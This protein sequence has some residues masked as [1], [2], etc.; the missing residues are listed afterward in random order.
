MNFLP[1]WGINK[2][3]KEI[4]MH[5][6][7]FFNREKSAVTLL[8]GVSSVSEMIA[9]A[10][11]AQDQGAD[12]VAFEI[13]WLPLEERTVEKFKAVIESVPLPFMFICYRND[14]FL[15][16]DD[17]ARQEY[18]LRAVDAGAEVVDVM[19]DL[20]DPSPRELTFNKEA[21][22]KQK[23]LIE[24][25]HRRGGKVIM[26]SHM[27]EFLQ[28][29]E[30]L[31]HMKE[32]ASRGADILKMV[33]K[34]DTEEE[35]VKTMETFFLLKKE[36]K[37]DYVFLANGKFGPLVRYLGLKMGVAIEFAARGYWPPSGAVQPTVNS[38]RKVEENLHWRLL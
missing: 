18:L 34:V 7:S 25:I 4:I 19:G 22:T 20:Y 8:S 24:E 9:L 23:A 6:P 1:V 37:Q 38:F 10:K 29:Q 14:Q 2:E 36:I 11:T 31:A 35:M 28:P 27:Q 15:K 26:S 32:Q 21:I 33:I 13:L 30:V 5:K 3:R 16:G 17:E 12:A